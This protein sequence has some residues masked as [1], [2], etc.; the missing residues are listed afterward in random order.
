VPDG[1]EEPLPHPFVS[2]EWFAEMEKLRP[3][4]PAAPPALAGL[5]V[6]VVVTGGPAGEVEVHYQAGQ[7]NRGLVPDAPTKVTVPYEVA[8]AVFIDSNQAVAMQAFMSGQIKVEGDLG[9][10]IA[11]QSSGPLTPEQLALQQRVRDITS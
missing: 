6:N 5:V 3:S 11:M 1:E 7:F 10:L 9:K 8:K 2:E 4:A